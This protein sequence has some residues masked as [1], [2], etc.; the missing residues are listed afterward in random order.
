MRLLALRSALCVALL[1]PD[2]LVDTRVFLGVYS[3]ECLCPVWEMGA[4][5]EG[6]VSLPVLGGREKGVGGVPFEAPKKTQT[7]SIVMLRN[8]VYFLDGPG[9]DDDYSSCSSSSS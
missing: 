8:N 1:D 2:R 6:C 5:E 4:G 9:L 7:C 3:T